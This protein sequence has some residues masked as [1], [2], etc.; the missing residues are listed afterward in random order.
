MTDQRLPRLVE[1]LHACGVRR[2]HSFAWRDLDDPEAGGSEV[3][4]DEI[5]RRWAS[6]GV[7]LVH[8]T[9]TFDTARTFQRNG[10]TVVQE[11]GRVGVLA[12]TPW[13]GL[14]RDRH[15]ADAV[16]D[17][18]NGVPWW[19]PVWFAGPRVTWL[20]HLHSE[21]W[22]QSFPAPLAF[23]GRTVES[24]IAPFLYRH[25]QIVTLSA[26][27]KAGLLAHGF[28]D[29]RV[30]VV[31][32]GVDARF[33]PVRDA[34]ESTPLIVAVGRL[35]P[36]K[37]YLALADSVAAYREAMP[38]VRLEIVGDGPDRGALEQWRDAHDAGDWFVLRG[39]LSDD[40]LVATYRRAWV[41]VSASVAEGWGMSLT[42][43]AACGTPGVATDIAGHR[44]AVT[45]GV[46]GVLV[47]D[48]AQ[49][50]KVVASL[51]ADPTRLAMLG[52]GAVE[53]AGSLTWDAA[54]A[55]HLDVLVRQ[56]EGAAGDPGG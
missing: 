16:I 29:E 32:P 22:R 42:E 8:R 15:R 31:L 28:R 48:V 19:S 52:R 30:E 1:R 2:V 33:T 11:G 38:G 25:E 35:A 12:R 27:S 24:R 26:T 45:D 5:F 7:E 6:A 3:H 37:R 44:D 18:W 36:V 10:Y 40:E 14:R 17:I 43:A 9:S 51:V 20:H 47:A 13:S 53:R 4:A 49:L 39:R 50:G 41:A 56:C 46:S 21:M 23:A 34:T 54:A 55:A